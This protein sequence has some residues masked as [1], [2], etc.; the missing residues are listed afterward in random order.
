MQRA[1]VHMA[2]T[3]SGTFTTVSNGLYIMYGP[4]VKLLQGVGKLLQSLGK[5]PQGLFVMFSYV[6]AIVQ[7]IL[8]PV[9][10][11]IRFVLLPIWTIVQF[12]L[13]PVTYLVYGVYGLIQ[14]LFRLQVLDK[15]EVCLFAPSQ[16]RYQSSLKR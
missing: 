8:L 15:F 14:L 3:I 5:L 16:S 7:S 4:A 2:E 12:I 9:W 10:T 13:L 1:A 6:W 11:V